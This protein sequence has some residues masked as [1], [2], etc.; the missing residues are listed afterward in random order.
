MPYDSI[1]GVRLQPLLIN[2][3]D[4]RLDE[5]YDSITG[6]RLQPLLIFSGDERLDESYDG[7]FDASYLPLSWQALMPRVY[8]PSGVINLNRN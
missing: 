7:S 8:A 6:E 1:A 3:G 2:S 4:E 5:S